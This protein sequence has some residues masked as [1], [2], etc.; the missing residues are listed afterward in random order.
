MTPPPVAGGDPGRYEEALAQW[1]LENTFFLDFVYRNPPERGGMGELGDAVVLFEDAAVM[2]QIKAQSSPRDPMLWAKKNLR[3]AV[4]QLKHTN[5]KLFDGH[6]HE[7]IN[8]IFG[9]TSF[10]PARYASRFGI[11]VLAQMAQPFDAEKAFPEL[12]TLPFPVHV[13]SLDDF[14][15]LLDRFNTAGDLIPYLEFRHDMRATLDR[16]VHAE[17]N[18]VKRVADQIE[19]FLPLVRPQITSE[20][21]ERTVRYFRLTASGEVS[22]SDDW[23]YSLTIDDMIA[24][25]HD[26]DPSLDWNTRGNP[27]DLGIIS[28]GLAWLNR[29]RRIALG[30][31]LHEFCEAAALDGKDHYFS[32]FQ[33]GTGVARVF[34]VTARAREDRVAILHILVSAALAKYN[35]QKALGV[36]TEPLGNGRSYDF[37]VREGQV[38]PE[39]RQALEEGK[40]LFSYEHEQLFK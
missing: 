31:R 37:V 20:V 12:G 34:L 7:L 13:F 26:R 2:V 22:R 17:A 35:A 24:R 4:R 14:V 28:A 18:T 8:P 29:Q 30:K 40:G 38:S 39:E 36:A 25:I 11:I 23:R 10:D 27:S 1:F 21:L 19:N 15:L 33:P 6:V 5:R 3:K 9:K 32:H 16:K